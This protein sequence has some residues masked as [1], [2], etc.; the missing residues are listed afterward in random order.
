MTKSA[1]TDS[2]TSASL[3]MDPA[4]V[5]LQKAQTEYA[6]ALEGVWTSLL[7]RY[8]EAAEDC[9]KAQRELLANAQANACAPAKPK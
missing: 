8:N 5:R 3:E 4:L 1:A 6:A 7:Q 9:L 2:S